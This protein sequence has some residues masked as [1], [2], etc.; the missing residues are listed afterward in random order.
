LAFPLVC[1]TGSDPNALPVK[2]TTNSTKSLVLFKAS[3]PCIFTLSLRIFSSNPY[4]SMK[5]IIFYSKHYIWLI[6]M[7][8]LLTQSCK[9][10]DSVAPSSF[11][12][13][14]FR[15]FKGLHVVGT[16]AIKNNVLR[17]TPRQDY[18]AGACWY[19]T[20]K[21]SV[22]SGFETTFTFKIDSLDGTAGADGFAFVIHNDSARLNAIGGFGID[23]GYGGIKNS[24]AIEFD[25]YQNATLGDL[26]DNHISVHS[27]GMQTNTTNENASLG[28]QTPIASNMSAGQHTVKISYIP[29]TLTVQLNNETVKTVQV[30]LST[31]LVLDQGKA[32]VGFTAATGGAWQIQD[33]LNWSFQSK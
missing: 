11:T 32:Y 27:K 9:K 12:Y 8:L 19:G 29:G 22:Q 6:S 25:M 20:S 26:N 18:R 5:N 3:S 7:V 30:D 2:H 1:F 15:N 24:L 4:T 17:L 28:G 31:Q 16:T 10:D 13:D 23:L 14:N 33:I 21:M